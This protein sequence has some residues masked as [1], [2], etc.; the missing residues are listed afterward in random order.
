VLAAGF[1][2]ASIP[3]AGSPSWSSTSSDYSTGGG[4]ADI[5]TNGYVDFCM[6]NGNDMALD[7][8]AVYLNHNG[9]LENTASW[10]S[11]DNGNY[12]H[13]YLGDVDNDGLTDMAVAYLGPAGDHKTRVY[14]NVGGALTRSPWWKSHD[15]TT[16]FDCCLGDVNN[17][18]WLDVAIS[19]GDAYSSLAE[20]LKI[21]FNHSGILD[22]LPG[23]LSANLVQSDA[24]RLA[25]LNNDGKL[26]LIADAKSRV[27]VYYQRGDTLER[28]PS[29]IDTTGSNVMGLRIA[30]GDYDRDGWLDVAVVCNAQIGSGNAIRIYHN[31]AGTLTKPPAYRLQLRNNYSACVAWG[32]AN[33]DGWL[34]LAAGGWWE[35]VVVYENHAGVLD[36]TPAWSWAHGDNLVCET[37]TWADVRNQYLALLDQTAS[38]NGTRK[39]FYLDHQPVQQFLGVEVNGTPVPRVDYCVDPLTGYVSLH[40]APPSGADNV[41]FRYVYSTHPDLGVTNWEPSD[42]NYVFYNTTPTTVAE[43]GLQRTPAAAITASP[44]FFSKS[45]CLQAKIPMNARASVKLYSADGRLIATIAEN[46]GPGSHDL[47]Y[48]IAPAGL[49]EGVA[50]V[51]MYCSD[52]TAACCKVVRVN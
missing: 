32:D 50:F 25:D 16:H 46:L 3:L 44:S 21:Y 42:H 43:Q 1:V 31:D 49:T 29:W 39:L 18:G 8:N 41:L 33:G 34:D 40:D 38:G 6:S 52:G 36:T 51:K 2:H 14:R 27:Y 10:R 7:Y 9:T 48:A 15:S 26:D 47:H 20:P 45:L 28:E 30:V 12:G 35:P 13:L 23:W 4:F 22:T 19:A 5:D 17:D 24:V 11:T 37:V